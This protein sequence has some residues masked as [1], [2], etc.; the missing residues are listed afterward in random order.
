MKFAE[1]SGED[2]GV[3]K[4]EVVVDAVEV[5]GHGGDEVCAVLM[6]VVCAEFEAGDFG[7]RIRLVS[8]L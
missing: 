5:G 7:D 6:R 2:M 3:S 8:R 4:I 1:E